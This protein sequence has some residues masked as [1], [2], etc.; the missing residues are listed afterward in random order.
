MKHFVADITY[1]DEDSVQ[2]GYRYEGEN[3]QDA[4]NFAEKTM[5][6]GLNFFQ[7]MSQTFHYYP[8]YRILH[9]VVMTFED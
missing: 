9:V 4:L 6:N 3:L 1:L 5:Q 8:L 2:C 7:P